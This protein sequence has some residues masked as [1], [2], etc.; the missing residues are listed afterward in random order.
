MN[1]WFS[2]ILM[3]IPMLL[4][5]CGIQIQL[6]TLEP[7]QVNLQRGASLRVVSVH[8]N[9]ASAHLEDAL[10]A[11]LAPEN[12]YT[13]GGEDSILYIERAHVHQERYLT[14]TCQDMEHCHCSES[15]ETTL[16]VTVQ[17]ERRG[18]ILYRRTL[19]DTSY[20]DYVD[21]DDVAAEIVRDLVPRTVRYSV[22]IK[23]QEDNTLLEQA[24]QACRLGDW[25]TGRAL[26]ESSL[27]TFPND[28]EAYY[29]LGIIERNN[30]NYPASNQY[31]LKAAGIAPS[32][33]YSE[34]IRDNTL[35]QAKENLAISQ[36]DG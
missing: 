25:A 21:Y 7:S 29:L 2:L 6:H 20:S 22:R 17:L 1:R 9:Y 30:R 33:R 31:F 36:L 8:G 15:V 3:A 28:P 10:Y 34:A 27:Q 32:A 13:L 24:A 5:S 35:M 19:S 4:C 16:H 11:R 12:F 26:A 14:H 18:N 23:P